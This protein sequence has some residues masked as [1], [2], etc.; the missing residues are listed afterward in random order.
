MS[1]NFSFPCGLRASFFCIHCNYNRYNRWSQ[2]GHWHGSP[3]V[4]D[5]I[6]NGE[7]EMDIGESPGWIGRSI[8]DSH[9]RTICGLPAPMELNSPLYLFDASNAKEAGTPADYDNGYGGAHVQGF[10]DLWDT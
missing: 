3:F 1:E 7:V 5:L 6:Q 10:H 8:M 4:L 2:K 9:F